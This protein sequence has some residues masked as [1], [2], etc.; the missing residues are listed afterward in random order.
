ML[1][2]VSSVLVY[3]SGRRALVS[4]EDSGESLTLEGL[5]TRAFSP[6]RRRPDVVRL[7]DGLGDPSGRVGLGGCPPRPPTDPYVRDYRIRFFGPRFRYATSSRT[8]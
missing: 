4:R 7:P 8:L 6:P 3:M 2:I 5:E 1:S